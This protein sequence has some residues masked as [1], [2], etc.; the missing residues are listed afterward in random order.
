MQNEQ[1]A[2]VYIYSTFLCSK[3]W[4]KHPNEKG[5]FLALLYQKGQGCVNWIWM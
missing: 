3:L 4:Q 2:S 5:D 1:V